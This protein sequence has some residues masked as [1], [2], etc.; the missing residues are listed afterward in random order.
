MKQAYPGEL[1]TE[2]QGSLRLV[3]RSIRPPFALIP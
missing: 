2:G 1:Q 3:L